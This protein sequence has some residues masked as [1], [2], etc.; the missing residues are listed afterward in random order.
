[1]SRKIVITSGKGG[2][3]KTTVTAN[4]G[5]RLASMGK[6]VC[7]VDAD[8]GLN[9]LDVATGVEQSVVYDVIDCIEGRC[10][11]KQALIESPSRKN[12]FV[13]P[14]A[15]S[16]AR[17]EVNANSFNEL[18]E[19]LSNSFDYVLIDC[20]AGVGGGFHKAITSSD[21]A[22]I[23]T[24]LQLSALR[25]AD[26]VIG[27]VKSY[28]L[29]KVSLVVN[30]VRGDLVADKTIISPEKAEDI[31]KTELIG[32]IP[33][34]DGLLLNNAVNLP[35]DSPSYKAFKTLASNVEKN[36]NKIFNYSADYVGFL[37]SI[38]RGLKRTL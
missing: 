24:A 2:V 30:M 11:A 15:H 6:R 5:Y 22:I 31:L 20:P 19:G 14:S 7:L 35:C 18:I 12:L 10:R 37:G 21:E 3:G 38:R 36:R 25:D 32:V 29:K 4:L 17:S 23:V 16:F 8:F 27:I 9:N 1:M 33:S 13:L 28:N 26:K 34:D